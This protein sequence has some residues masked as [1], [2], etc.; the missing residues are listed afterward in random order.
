VKFL[1]WCTLT[2]QLAAL[3]RVGA[4]TTRLAAHPIMNLV[5]FYLTSIR[6]DTHRI[7][8]K[9]YRPDDMT[10]SSTS[11]WTMTSTTIATT[12]S[13]PA[14]ITTPTVSHDMKHHQ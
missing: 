1:T 13:T 8:V 10:P 7:S 4:V 9:L 12:V 6:I 14:T 3:F 2:L 5:C 11:Q